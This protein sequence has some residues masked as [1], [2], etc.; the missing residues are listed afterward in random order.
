MSTKEFTGFLGSHLERVRPLLREV[1]LAYW[2]ATISGKPVDF[3]RSAQLQVEL[4]RVYSNAGDFDKIRRWQDD[5]SI[6]DEIDRRQ[7][8]LL[9][10]TYLRNQVDPSLNERITKLQSRIENLFNV[11]RANVDGKEATSNDIRTILKQSHNLG[12][13]KKAWEAGKQV[14][15]IVRDDLL[16]LVRLRNEAARSLG[17]DNYYSMSMA[18]SEQDETEIVRL[19]GEL[20]ERTREPFQIMKDEV[21]GRLAARFG[22]RPGEIRPWHYEDPFFQEAPRVYDVELDSYY[23][24]VDILELTKRFYDGIGLEVDEILSR[25]DLYEKPGKDQHAYCTDIDRSGD[26]RILANIKNDEMWTGT[27][28]HE[29]GHAVHDRYI[30][31]GLPFLLRQEAHIFTTEAIAMLFGRLSKD[32]DWIKDTTGITEAEKERVAGDLARGLRLHQ[33]IFARWSQV[34]LHFER[35]LYLDP[36]QDLNGRW[37]V[38]AQKYQMLTAPEDVGFPHWAAKTHIVSV[39]VYYHNYLLGELLASQLGHHIREHILPPGATSSF[40]GHAPVG[41]YLKERFFAPGARYRWDKLIHKATGEDLSPK[42]FVREFV[43][44]AGR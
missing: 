26:I 9:Y 41:S 27:L 14:G 5:P 6:A 2:T 34:M 19:F 35:Q 28:L 10:R 43:D 42:Y 7:I 21:D 32:P 24:N 33:V 18:L 36:D 23:S 25:S 11:F 44:A 3:E 22:I 12:L 1:N 15:T 4:Q 38:L 39:P 8:D 31:P 40:C 29:L 16:T 20:E 17:H 13:R 30:D 37:W